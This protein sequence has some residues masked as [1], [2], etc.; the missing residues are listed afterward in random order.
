MNTP[1]LTPSTPEQ[2]RIYAD[3]WRCWLCQISRTA[4]EVPW[5]TAHEPHINRHLAFHETTPGDPF[6]L[7]YKMWREAPTLA[8]HFVC[9]TCRAEHSNLNLT[10]VYCWYFPVGMPPARLAV[11]DDCTRCDVDF[12]RERIK[13]R[14]RA[15]IKDAKRRDTRVYRVA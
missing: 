8:R 4:L 13:E 3:T 9:T 5:D 7:Q 12:T 6:D 15:E 1:L 11:L 10:C 14:I 2:W